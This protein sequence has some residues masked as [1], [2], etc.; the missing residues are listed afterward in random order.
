MSM[1]ILEV[2]RNYTFSI[3][4]HCNMCGAPTDRARLLGLR[5]DKTQGI[6]PR[7]K[8]GVAVSVCQCRSCGLIFPYPM[9]TP[10]SLSDHYGMPPESY[11]KSAS[12][13]PELGYFSRQIETAKKILGKSEIRSIDV[14]LGLG[15]ASQVMKAEGFD[16]YGF[17]A[18]RPFFEK[19]I[20]NLGG[21]DPDRFKLAS[22][23]DVE[24]EKNSF[25]FVTFGA[26]LEHLYDPASA[27]KKALNWLKFGG[28]IHI[29]VPSSDYFM[30]KL[31][32]LF[33]LMS[34][35][36]YVTNISPMHSPFHLYEFSRKSFMING[37]DNGY[38]IV[39]SWFDV[40][41]IYHVHRFFHPLLRYWMK[42]N[43]S[44]MQLTV[45]LQKVE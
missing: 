18:S 42:V 23:D 3:A 35:T 17:E 11:W 22:I 34:G 19:A 27:I 29:E 16:V 39:H 26:V 37:S 36:N 2:E 13:I 6:N 7:S 12:P 21:A 38:K 20:E 30:S 43:N 32:N 8:K 1:Q 4:S 40:A 5:L 24:F 45:F 25:D 41:S 28:I 44:G 31:F 15:K 9:P 33:Y 14:G 10:R